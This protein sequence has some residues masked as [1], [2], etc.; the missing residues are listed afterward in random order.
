[1]K[2]RKLPSP[3]FQVAAVDIAIAVGVAVGIIDFGD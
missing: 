1:L 2:L 3:G